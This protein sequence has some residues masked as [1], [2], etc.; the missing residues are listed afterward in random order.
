MLTHFGAAGGSFFDTSD[1]HEMLIARP[2]D[3]QDNAVP[4]GNGM[5]VWVLLRLA[6]LA[7]E[8]HYA[9]M[10]RQGLA[11]MQPLLA[12]YPLAFGQWLI[13]L[14]YAL[15]HPR[16]IAIMGN[17]AAPDT[18]A[19]LEACC[20]GYSPHQV[21]AAGPT[22]AIPLLANR[23][24]IE[25]RATAYVCVDGTCR[26]PVTDPALLRGVVSHASKRPPHR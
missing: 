26:P 2:R 1:E 19:L 20:T 14:D 13:A 4:S 7:A 24:Q 11:A 8:P 3:M 9:D 5:A 10:A 18:R 23:G 25:G 6:G 22:G 16:E 15:A 17:P 21:V 12:R